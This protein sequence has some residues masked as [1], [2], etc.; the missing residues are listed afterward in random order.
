MSKDF[1]SILEGICPV[2]DIECEN[3][4]L[5]KVYLDYKEKSKEVNNK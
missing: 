1:C 5:Q 4:D 3:C 2:M